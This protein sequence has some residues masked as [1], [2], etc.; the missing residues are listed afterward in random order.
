[1][2]SK[3]IV[4]C[5]CSLCLLAECVSAPSLSVSWDSSAY[6]LVRT[7]D[8]EKI[9]L[10]DFIIQNGPW[11]KGSIADYRQ[12]IFKSENS[13]NIPFGWKWMWPKER[14]DDVKSY[15]ALS[16]GWNPWAADRTNTI[17]LAKIDNIAELRVGYTAEVNASGKYNLS[18]DF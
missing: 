12:W 14:V 5:F 9:F 3:V 11:E 17:L 1:M 15:Q 18:F 7:N 13:S 10:G 2:Y 8:W 6:A 4:R 16:Y